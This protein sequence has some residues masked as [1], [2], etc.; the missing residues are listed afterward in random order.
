MLTKLRLLSLAVFVWTL[1]LAD[2][3]TT[4]PASET[5]PPTP[6]TIRW[7]IVHQGEGGGPKEEKTGDASVNMPLNETSQITCIAEDSEGVKGVTLQTEAQYT[8]GTGEFKEHK[9]ILPSQNKID[10]K[11]DSNGQIPTQLFLIR[12]IS[13][14]TYPCVGSTSSFSTLTCQAE[15]SFGR[16]TKAT[17]SIGRP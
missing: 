14:N 12:E 9:T 11:P 10:G 1:S 6:P 4:K 3:K 17:L 2:C 16:T 7:S 13:P 8:C 5:V 15:N